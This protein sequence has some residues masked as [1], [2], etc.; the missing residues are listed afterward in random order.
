MPW[1]DTKQFFTLFAVLDVLRVSCQFFQVTIFT[2]NTPKQLI[3]VGPVSLTQPLD[4][5]K[6]KVQA[7]TS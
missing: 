2:E 6:C 5:I 7:L 1:N 3:T 4:V